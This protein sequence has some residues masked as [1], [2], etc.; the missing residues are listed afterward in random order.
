MINYLENEKS[1]LLGIVG[2]TINNTW[3]SHYDMIFE[4]MVTY[5]STVLYFEI[6]FH[7]SVNI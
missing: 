5:F 6:S 3:V 1:T 7:L 2:G 4:K